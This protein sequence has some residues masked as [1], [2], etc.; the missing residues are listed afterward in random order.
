MI[1]LYKYLFYRFLCLTRRRAPEEVPEASAFICMI[2]LLW[3]NFLLATIIVECFFRVRLLP[4]LSTWE[5]ALAMAGLALPLYFLLL[6]RGAPK[7]ITAEFE[8]ETPRQKR[9]RG[10]FSVSYVVGS[11]VLIA[12]AS[13]V[14]ERLLRS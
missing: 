5:V 11:F 6:H 7:K 8:K 9:V 4:H 14:R 10:V 3:Q 1:R 2:V 12:V 13:L